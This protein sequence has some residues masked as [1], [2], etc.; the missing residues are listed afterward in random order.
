MYVD[1]FIF[2]THDTRVLYTGDFRLPPCDLPKYKALHNSY[3]EVKKIDAIYLDTTF[4]F[5][6][7][8]TF[9]SRE[10]SK[11]VLINIVKQWLYEGTNNKVGI[12]PPGKRININY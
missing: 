2:E 7:F 4:A 8:K 3:G 10:Q 6:E 9:P 12:V 5:P 11:N 1:R